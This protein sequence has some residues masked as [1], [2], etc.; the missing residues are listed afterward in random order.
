MSGFDPQVVMHRLNIKLD[1]KPVKQ[2]QRGFAPTSWKQSKPKFINSSNAASF[3]RNSTQTRLLILSL[4]SR[5]TERSEFALTSVISMQPVLRTNILCT[6]L[7]SWLTIHVALKK[8]PSWMAFQ[9]TI[10]SRCTRMMRSIHHS[11]RYWDILLH[12]NAVRIEKCGCNLPT[13]H[14]H[15]FSVI[16]YGKWWTAMLTILQSRVAAEA[17]ISMT[18]EPYST[19]C[20]LTSW[21]WTWPNHSWECRVASSLNSSSHPK[22]FTLTLTKL[23]PFRACNLR[24]P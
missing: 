11:K 4:C 12:S 13:R 14:E 16:I 5:K 8:C 6:S 24:G 23:R 17:T 22:K 19:S 1:A 10:K 21:K 9:G 7:I 2:Q 3:K 20:R 15:N 18:W